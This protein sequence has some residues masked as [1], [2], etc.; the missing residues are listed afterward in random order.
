MKLQA[1]VSLYPLR[2]KGL[3]SPINAFYT[4]MARTGVTLDPGRM[5]TLVSGD[6]AQVFA[7]IQR[8]FSEVAEKQQLVLVVKVSNACLEPKEVPDGH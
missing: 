2:T 4:S 3:S 7:A 5:S 1:E 6:S 8:A